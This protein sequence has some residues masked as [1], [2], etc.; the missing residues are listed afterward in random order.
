MYRKFILIVAVFFLLSFSTRALCEQPPVAK[1]ERSIE[2]EQ[3]DKDVK[4][5]LETSRIYWFDKVVLM[6]NGEES[7]V[8]EALAK[9]CDSYKGKF[10]TQ[11]ELDGFFREI[12]GFFR[13]KSVAFKKLSIAI[14]KEVLFIEMQ[15]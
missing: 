8:P 3:H 10:S 7:P 5:W 6:Q 15:L 9:L 13:E 12:S 2:I 11:K 14:K 1:I 4:G